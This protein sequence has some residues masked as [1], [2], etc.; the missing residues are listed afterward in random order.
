METRLVRQNNDSLELANQLLTPS[1]IVLSRELDITAGNSKTELMRALSDE[2]FR[3][4]A[5]H[6]P[7]VI[8]WVFREHRKESE[9][10]PAQVKLDA[11]FQRYKAIQFRKL[12]E[13]KS[14]REKELDRERELSGE[15][16]TSLV[17]IM[18]SFLKKMDSQ[19]AIPE[20]KNKRPSLRRKREKLSAEK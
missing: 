8:E 12:Q 19:K 18:Q 1:E 10:W 15:E 7:E 11:L 3:L 9:F 16:K 13:E 20:L 2:I 5:H 4:Y 6:P 14:R 17:E